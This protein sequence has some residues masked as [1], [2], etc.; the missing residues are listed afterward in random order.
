MIHMY[1]NNIAHFLQW[2]YTNKNMEKTVQC[3]AENFKVKEKDCCYSLKFPITNNFNN[4]QRI[5][6][7]RKTTN[8][9]HMNE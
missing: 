1:E 6:I 3:R 8:H 4:I 9:A 5:K 7:T 2:L